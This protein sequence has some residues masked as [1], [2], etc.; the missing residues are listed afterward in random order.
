VRIDSF[1]QVFLQV[2]W[3]PYRFHR[4]SFLHFCLSFRVVCPGSL[5]Q[6]SHFG[7]GG[8]DAR[9]ASGLGPE[10]KELQL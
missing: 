7:F 10:G 3:R 9:I 6:G 5:S 4:L 1:R 8:Y 2:V